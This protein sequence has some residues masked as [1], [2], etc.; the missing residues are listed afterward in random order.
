LCRAFKAACFGVPAGN[1]FSS[2]F[3]TLYLIVIRRDCRAP[4]PPRVSVQCTN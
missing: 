2:S 1:G 3:S 4:P